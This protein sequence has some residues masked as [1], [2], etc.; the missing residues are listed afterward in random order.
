VG[1]CGIRLFQE[2]KPPKYKLSSEEKASGLEGFN[3]WNYLSKDNQWSWG[4]ETLVAQCW[5][6]RLELVR[7][8]LGQA[9]ER[10]G[11]HLRENVEKT[12]DRTY[13]DET[14]CGYS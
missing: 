2:N 11:G 5:L 4:R 3:F 8:R 7:G 12:K 1:H 9:S 6:D 13:G 14:Q 10:T